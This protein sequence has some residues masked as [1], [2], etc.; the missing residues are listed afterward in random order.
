MKQVKLDDILQAIK[1]KDKN[2]LA[3]KLMGYVLSEKHYWED[4][5]DEEM[6]NYYE[7][8]WNSLYDLLDKVGYYNDIKKGV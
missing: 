3:N 5:N 1:C 4:Q 8:I 6:V 2:Q 7:G